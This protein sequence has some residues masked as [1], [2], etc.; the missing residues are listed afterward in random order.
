MNQRTKKSLKITG[1]VIVC[2]LALMAI[3]PYAFR[4]KIEKIVITEGNKMLNARFGFE[5]LNISLFKNFPKASISLNNFYLKG[6]D[7]FAK[8]TLV[9]AG[10]ATVAIDLFSLFG[11]SGYDVSKIEISDAYIH[12]IVL[13]NGKVNWDIMK[14]D[15]TKVTPATEE[16]T[17]FK[18]KLKKLTADN[19]NIIY[20]DRQADMYASIVGLNTECSGDLTADRSTLKIA[21]KSKGLTFKMGAIPYISNAVVSA[22]MDLDADL[23]HSKYTLKENKFQLNAIKADVDG[24]VAMLNNGGTDM[25]LKVNTN[26]V[27][28]KDVLSLIPAIYAK[29][30]EDVKATGNVSLKFNAKGIMLGDTLPAFN[31]SMVVK[32]GTFKYPSLP[33][34]VDQIN[35]NASVKNPGGST[36]LTEVNINP[37]S[38]RM[39]GNQFS[40]TSII[41][42]PVSDP[43]VKGS[44]KG[45]LNLGM[46]KQVYPLDEGM[47]LNGIISADVN[48]AGRMS[49]IEKEQYD[50]FQASGSLKL[51]N[52]KLK[53]KDMPDVDI[54]RSTFTFSPKYLN[55]S[56]TTVKIGKNDITADC[57]L[58]NYMGYVLKDKTL[59]GTMNIK[60]NYFNLN[61]FM[62]TTS[63]TAAGA[64]GTTQGAA[65]ATTTTSAATSAIEVPKNIDFNM[66][67]NMKQVLFDKMA[68]NNMNGKLLV[69]DGKVDM[70]NLSMNT[71]GGSVVM[72]GSYSTAQS[73]KSPDLNAGFK[74]NSISFAQAYKE[75]DMVQK[76]APIFE[77]LKGDFS[78]NMNISTKLDNQLSPVFNSMQGAGSLSTKDISLSGV[79]V[80][81]K[82][83]TAVKKE[84][85]KNLKV[86][87]MKIDF[88]I[89]DGRV[90]TKP[91]DIK[92]GET[93]LNLSGT[94][95]LDQT[96]D[97]S[98]KIKLPAS[99]GTLG[100]LS[101]LDLKIGGTFTSP[102][103]SIDTKSMAKQVLSS[104]KNKAISEVGKKL[105]IDLG[106]AQKQKE[107]LVT[108]A[109]KAGDKLVAEA[110]KQAD[111]L[112]AKAGGNILKKLAAQKAGEV[113]VKEA[114]KESDKLVKEAEAQGDKL[115]EKAKSE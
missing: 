63:T 70:Q 105:G 85:L 68:F 58:E 56:E 109:Q 13:K 50:K 103:V 46:I 66:T 108:N 94:T 72:N 24:W 83:A 23:A 81:D 75:L 52:M 37:F 10:D 96:I 35:I 97:Y 107:A 99:T 41:K 84:S 43:D 40:L 114:K 15:T 71:M 110:Q 104:A 6:I 78:G 14:T 88:T 22:D 26:E 33:M 47:A 95:G 25:D 53:M 86:K 1:L 11:S 17:P 62:G 79:N 101:T 93:L 67:A 36:D 57:R 3:L 115:I 60:S 31:A 29:D 90:S 69:K 77:G 8:D 73:V 92:F 61:D 91:F 48:M 9:K 42:T 111:D 76:M 80:I 112:V 30:F 5:D 82:I 45:T 49:Y 28:F 32:N 113:L 27:G 102:K 54:Q 20:D 98:G 65:A 55:L 74:M 51:S 89:K 44:A 12:A 39:A 2:I 19:V 87:D 7:E 34:G 100:Q 106:D 18:L 16:T 4:G 64:S 38:F 59:K 21:A